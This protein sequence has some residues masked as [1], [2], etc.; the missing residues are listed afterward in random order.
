MSNPQLIEITVNGTARALTAS[1]TVRE[2]V[3]AHIG[4]AI[5]AEGTA[6]DGGRLGV[7]VARNSVVVPRSR[8][9][10]TALAAGDAVEIVTAAQGG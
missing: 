9:A 2:L 7:A 5:T 10:A 8:W 3:G 6:A 1:E 4:R